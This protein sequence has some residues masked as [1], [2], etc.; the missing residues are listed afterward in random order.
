MMST[1]FGIHCV[2]VSGI[3]GSGASRWGVISDLD[4]RAAAGPDA[5]ERSGREI[6]HEPA[7]TVAPDE[8]LA[9]AAQLMAEHEVSHLVVVRS[10]GAIIRSRLDA[11]RGQ[12]A[13]VGRNVLSALLDLRPD[14]RRRRRRRGRGLE[15]L[16]GLRTMVGEWVQLT[17]VAPVDS[18][19]LPAALDGEPVYVP[20]ERRGSLSGPAGTARTSS[21]MAWRTWTW[22]AGV[23][24]QATGT[25][26]RRRRRPRDGR[27]PLTA[28]ADWQW[29]WVVRQARR[30]SPACSR[31]S[32]RHSPPGRD[33]RSAGAAAGRRLRARAGRSPR[34]APHARRRGRAPDVRAGPRRHRPRAKRARG[35]VRRRAGPY[36]R[37]AGLRA[38]RRGRGLDV[39]SAAAR[40]P[41]RGSAPATTVERSLRPI[42]GAERFD[43]VITLRTA[44]G[45]ALG[46]V[47]ND[48]KGFLPV[49]EHSRVTGASGCSCRRRRNQHA[50]EA[51]RTG[52]RPGRRRR[53]RHRLGG[54][55]VDPAPW[56]P[57]STGIPLRCRPIFPA[58]ANPSG[59]TAAS[60]ATHCLWWPP[61]HVTGATSSPTS[62]SATRSCAQASSG[63]PPGTLRPPTWRAPPP[64]SAHRPRWHPADT[65]GRDALAR[66]LLAIGRTQR[67]GERLIGTLEGHCDGAALERR[68]R[69]VVARPEAADIC[70]TTLMREP[71]AY[72]RRRTVPPADKRTARR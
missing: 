52:R 55:D 28:D 16:V 72:A 39:F 56:S 47:P 10:A 69:E 62:R 3:G 58:G 44:H 5:A 33:G 13:Q 30:C 60:L 67:A 66:Q 24:S 54:G 68:N 9:R 70:A 59:W 43:R 57:T 2:I 35:A 20:D 22:I 21:A 42:G 18:F 37:G 36:R 63:H 71:A 1:Y 12:R 50:P 38:G 25:S 15:T 51:Q 31:R 4:L 65:V 19:R 6:A 46:G 17:L 7:V 41:G 61:G 29:T 40:I 32:R 49:D 14:A 11:R 23:C 27:A 34:D 53:R 64:R 48:P 8:T 26:S 45:P